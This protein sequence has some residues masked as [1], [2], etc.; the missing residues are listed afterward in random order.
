MT[1]PP[2]VTDPEVSV[3]LVHPGYLQ[4]DVNH[5]SKTQN[6]FGFNEQRLAFSRTLP[7]PEGT[8]RDQ[9]SAKMQDGKL[10]ITLKDTVKEGT[11][12]SSSSS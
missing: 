5:T 6:D 3:H 9:V 8:T 12:S 4:V 11:T 7:L 1:M 10:V 2:G